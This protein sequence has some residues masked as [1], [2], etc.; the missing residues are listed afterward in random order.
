MS[1]ADWFMPL[2][3]SAFSAKK[4]VILNCYLRLAIMNLLILVRF[5]KTENRFKFLLRQ[6]LASITSQKIK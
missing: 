2:P 5:L 4:V 6:G 3:P 1:A